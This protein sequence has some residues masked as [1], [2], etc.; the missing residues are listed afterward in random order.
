M[1]GIRVS[2]K[3][4]LSSTHKEHLPVNKNKPENSIENRQKTWKLHKN[5]ILKW[6]TNI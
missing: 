1:F 4:P 5:R 2:N 6:S 3:V